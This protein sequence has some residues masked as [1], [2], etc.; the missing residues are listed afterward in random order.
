MVLHVREGMSE[1]WKRTQTCLDFSSSAEVKV[2]T[3][4]RAKVLFSLTI[5]S[6]IVIGAAV[7]VTVLSYISLRE[8]LLSLEKSPEED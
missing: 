2:S 3:G 1:K 7:A 5:F 8:C 6:I 4:I